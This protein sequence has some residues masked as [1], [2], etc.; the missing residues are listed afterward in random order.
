MSQVSQ[1][2]RIYGGR[3]KYESW[4]WKIDCCYNFVQFRELH[5]QPSMAAWRVRSMSGVWEGCKTYPPSHA[6]WREGGKAGTEVAFLRRPAAAST[7][8]FI[9]LAC[10]C[11]MLQAAYVVTS[12]WAEQLLFYPPYHRHLPRFCSPTWQALGE[13]SIYLERHTLFTVP[14]LRFKVAQSF[15]TIVLHIHVN[16]WRSSCNF[17]LV[18]H[19]SGLR[20]VKMYTNINPETEVDCF[21]I[22]FQ[23][24]LQGLTTF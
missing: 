24:F 13:W 11:Y 3:H 22:F 5:C 14:I 12:H 16:K 2:N 10:V 17:G 8:L 7:E 20:E 9:S 18:N 21:V 6:G 4:N 19:W 1:W 23:L 15:T